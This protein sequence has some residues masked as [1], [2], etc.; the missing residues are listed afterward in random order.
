M[1]FFFLKHFFPYLLGHHTLSGFHF[2][3]TDCSFILC[4]YLRD[5]SEL[6][7]SFSTS[8]P[9]LVISHGLNVTK[10]RWLLSMYL[11][12]Q[13]L[14]LSPV[15]STA[16]LPLGWLVGVQTLK[17]LDRMTGLLNTF[18]TSLLLAHLPFNPQTL[19]P[20]YSFFH[21]NISASY[22]IS[23]CPQPGPLTTPVQAS[24]LSLDSAFISSLVSLLPQ[25]PF[26]SLRINL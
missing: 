1:T 18:P 21:Q 10:H 25:L 6:G 2:Y 7:P 8:S 22:Y 3:I 24:H 5:A 19:N 16:R 23:P 11:Q 14:S 13:P 12:L 9:P 15:E 20:S 17:G 4:L 26:C